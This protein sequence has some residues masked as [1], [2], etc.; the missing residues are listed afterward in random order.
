VA[1]T[2]GE[3]AIAEEAT[4]EI[5]V[6]LRHKL[7]LSGFRTSDDRL[8]TAGVTRGLPDVLELHEKRMPRIGPEIQGQSQISSRVS[9]TTSTT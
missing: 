5:E 3:P 2:A 7:A 4:R 6:R 9:L 1:A 8:D